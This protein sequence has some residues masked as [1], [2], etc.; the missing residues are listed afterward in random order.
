MSSTNFIGRDPMQWWI[1][2]VTDPDKGEWGDSL[3][4]NT[5]LMME[6]TSM[7]LDVEFVSLDIMVMMLIYQIKIYHLAHVLLPP[8]TY[9]N[10]WLWYKQC[11][12][13]VEKL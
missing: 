11:N 2:Q 3:E 6:K 10:W 8:N 13:K 1:G 5:K 12:I 9:N 4:K 7:L